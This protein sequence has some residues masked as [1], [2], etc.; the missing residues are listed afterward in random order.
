M[1]VFLPALLLCKNWKMTAEVAQ[2]EGGNVFYELSSGQTELNSCCF[3]EPEFKN[4]DI[5][6]LKNDWK[7]SNSSWNLTENREV[8]DL[9]KTA[10]I[11]D[12]AL[13]SPDGDKIYL[14]VL[15]FWTPK[16]LKKRLD[17]Y[18][19]ANFRKFIFLAAQELRGSRE[20]PLWESEN[21]LFY[22]T[23]IKP[24]LLEEAAKNLA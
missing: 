6:K 15:G 22:K 5:E 3:D 1:A 2:K 21:V 10:F 20:E 4:S 16:A 24:L 14:D 19:A 13:V 7:N 17:E 9:G 11:P 18:E 23:K 12:F 8:V